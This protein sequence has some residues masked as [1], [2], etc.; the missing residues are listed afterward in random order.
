M[1]IKKKEVE[2]ME[3]TKHQRAGRARAEY[4]KGMDEL[5]K[6]IMEKHGLS[7]DEWDFWEYGE[8]FKPSEEW[9]RRLEELQVR[10]SRKYDVWIDHEEMWV[11]IHCN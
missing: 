2:N 11:S 8:D 6:E 5:Y 3:L 4:K 7:E 9:H 10:L 1:K